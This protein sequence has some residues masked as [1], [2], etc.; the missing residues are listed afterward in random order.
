MHSVIEEPHELI[1]D[2]GVAGRHGRG[3]SARH[4]LAVIDRMQGDY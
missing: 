3:A 1:D 2:L 4:E